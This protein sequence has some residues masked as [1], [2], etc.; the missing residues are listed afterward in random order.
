MGSNGQAWSRPLFYL[1]EYYPPLY[2]KLREEGF[3]PDDLDRNLSTLPSLSPNYRGR[4]RLYTLN[5]TFMIDF[6]NNAALLVLTEQGAEII[7]LM[8]IF[9]DRRLVRKPYTGACTYKLPSLA[10]LMFNL[11][12]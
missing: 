6:S 1:P 5:D 3:V 2:E 4:Q 7:R 12:S 10:T 8:T 9:H 11:F